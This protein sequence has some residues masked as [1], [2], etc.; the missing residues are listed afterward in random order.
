MGGRTLVEVEDAQ[1]L[2]SQVVRSQKEIWG[3]L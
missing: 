1:S 2:V 3:T